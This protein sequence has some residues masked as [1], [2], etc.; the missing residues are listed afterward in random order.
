MSLPKSRMPDFY[1]VIAAADAPALPH[2]R[3]PSYIVFLDAEGQPIDLGGSAAVAWS[4]IT[5]KPTVIA[6]GA[7]AAAARTAI[8]AGTPYT[9]PA[10]TASVSGGVKQAAAQANSTATDVAGLVADFNALLAKLKTA[11][12]MA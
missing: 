7:D 12:I 9:L 3:Y 1:E 6:A 11:G 8:G 10:A 5:G 2:G 4:A